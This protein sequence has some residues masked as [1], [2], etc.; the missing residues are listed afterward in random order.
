MI[1]GVLRGGVD[2]KQTGW[3]NLKLSHHPR[4]FAAT[5]PPAGGELQK[6]HSPPYRG[7]VA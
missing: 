7:G 1:H 3:L 6:K 4:C 2:A 5:P